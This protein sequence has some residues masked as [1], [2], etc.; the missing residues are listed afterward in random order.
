[1]HVTDRILG[2]TTMRKYL[3]EENE[4]LYS[5]FPG[6]KEYKGEGDEYVTVYLEA[7]LT[8]EEIMELF[9][10]DG[11]EISF[12]GCVIQPEDSID[13]RLHEV[14]SFE[15]IEQWYDGGV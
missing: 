5:E 3:P 14:H 15:E 11:E 1:M 8:T 13:W 12:E 6:L 4:K 9:M 7:Y 10:E 2:I